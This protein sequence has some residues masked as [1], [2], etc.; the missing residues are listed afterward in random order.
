MNIVGA[1]EVVACGVVVLSLMA[2]A[3]RRRQASQP[4]TEPGRTLS[5]SRS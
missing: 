3:G 1:L 2:R 5:R 4:G